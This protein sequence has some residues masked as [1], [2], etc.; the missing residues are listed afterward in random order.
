MIL[1]LLHFLLLTTTYDMT[2]DAFIYFRYVDNWIA[3]HGLT[4][5][6]GHEPVEGYTSFL[7]VLLLT[8]P[9]ALGA[10]LPSFVHIV[11]LAL[12]FALLYAL[13]RF[14]AV[15]IGGW[16]LVTLVAPLLAAS[17]SQVIIF[18]RGG[19]ETLLFALLLVL[20]LHVALLGSETRRSQVLSGALFG[21]LALTRPD[22]ILAYVVYV[23]YT[24]SACLLR[25][26]P[27]PLRQELYR[28]AGLLAVLVPHLLFRLA[29][30][31]ELAPNTFRAKVGVTVPGVMRGLKAALSYLT[32]L[33]GGLLIGAV[34]VWALAPRTRVGNVLGL[35]LLVWL[36]YLGS[37]GLDNMSKWYAMPLDVVSILWLGWSLAK[38]LEASSGQMEPRR[39]R[40]VGGVALGLLCVANAAFGVNRV[41]Y[42]PTL[43]AQ[44]LYQEP[45]DLGHYITNYIKVGKL[46]GKMAKP[47]E[48]MAVAECGAIPY[49]GGIV[50]YDALGLNDKHIAREPV[51]PGIWA[52]GHEKGD[53]R[54]LLAQKPTY[55]IMKPFLT[56]QPDRTPVGVP[57]WHQ[58]Y[59]MQEF[60]HDYEFLSIP[61]DGLFFNYYR[62][63]VA[64]PS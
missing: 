64:G 55:I 6:P 35:F 7:Y 25:K 44:G 63:R 52:F 45:S 34:G 8:I 39:L 54:Y 22:G 49:Y 46:I 56:S 62:R 51:A 43:F 37:I 57:S 60:K 16:R 50:T 24:V 31:G 15:G 53:G 14:V 47:G 23:G 59:D 58:M 41:L 36:L 17:S 48:T 10:H 9:A 18:T 4:W 33:R 3:G 20:A 27:L 32:S 29:Y 26:R 21:L 1:G 12:L 5:N 28:A 30:Y 19:M 38:L 61:V 11:N 42:T 2:D 13:A 40:W